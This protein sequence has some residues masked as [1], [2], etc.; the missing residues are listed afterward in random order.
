M[1]RARQRIW[2]NSTLVATV[3]ILA[4][5]LP[6]SLGMRVALAEDEQEA[7]VA[8]NTTAIVEEASAENE[9]STADSASAS[10]SSSITAD[11]SMEAETTGGQEVET[12]ELTKVTVTI[13]FVGTDGVWAEQAGLAIDEHANAWEATRLA[14]TNS[15]LAYHTGT[16]A[17][18]DVLVSITHPAGDETL[19]LD[20]ST[21]SGWR[22]YINGERCL[23]LPSSFGLGE[24][25]VVEWRYEVGTFM[26]SVSVV[27][28][29]GTGKS[30]WIAPTSVRVPA[31]HSVWDAS[32]EVFA[33]NGYE[34][35]RLL[36]YTTGAD[37]S[38]RLESLAALGE[39]GITGES[40][41]VFVNGVMPQSDA[42]HVVL[43]PGD[44]VCWYY[45]G[46]GE[47][48]LPSFVAQS[49]AASQDPAT[50]I[51]IDGVVVQAWSSTQD[52]S[53]SLFSIIDRMSGLA[54]TGQNG[55]ASLLEEGKKTLDPLSQLSEVGHWRSSLSYAL[56]TKL[57]TGE[58]IRSVM[59][60]DGSLYYLN[61]LGSIVKLELRQ[62]EVS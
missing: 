30:Y 29:G 57:S 15:H 48:V 31:T 3:L 18:Q 28:P 19:E 55:A 35:G 27:G 4:F 37:G 56:D 51:S 5:M 45:T 49:G 26:V 25:D 24:G 47:Y 62:S 54:I 9:A 22:L 6:T 58:G 1:N 61:D 20:S 11:N 34:E 7:D 36:S 43:H 8:T 40:W 38:V 42:A 2:R 12:S 16:D 10:A 13:R 52:T 41:Q 39:N 21:G 44:S 60:C 59:G 46:Q 32:L 33:T 17:A 50:T 14:L 53:E 23:G